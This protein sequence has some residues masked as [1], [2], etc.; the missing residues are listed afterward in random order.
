MTHCLSVGRFM[1]P[2]L[3]YGFDRATLRFS[4]IV[5][6]TGRWV[7]VAVSGTGE[8]TG[9]D[10]ATFPGGGEPSAVKSEFC[11]ASVLATG[12]GLMT[13][14]FMSMTFTL[15]RNAICRVARERRLSLSAHGMGHG[16]HARPS[17]SR[18]TVDSAVNTLIC[19]C[20]RAWIRQPQVIRPGGSK[21]AGKQATSG[22]SGCM[23]ASSLCVDEQTRWRLQAT[24]DSAVPLPGAAIKPWSG[25]MSTQLRTSSPSQRR[26][27]GSASIAAGRAV[28]CQ[29]SRRYVDWQCRQRGQRAA[30][31]V[32]EQSLLRSVA[33]VVPLLCEVRQKATLPTSRSPAGATCSPT[34]A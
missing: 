13:G 6:R 7:G 15:S 31:Q 19:V 26:P 28:G 21:P 12:A 5:A 33:R 4:V 1:A 22:Q 14:L 10:V 24:I 16:G 29:V 32:V 3:S 11:S 2:A 18:G 20:A 34:P 9:V 17:S 30:A 27:G 25:P 23:E 8:L